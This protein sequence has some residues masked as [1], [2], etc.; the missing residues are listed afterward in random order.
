MKEIWL[1]IITDI[2]DGGLTFSGAFDNENSAKECI[3]DE[4]LG[5]NSLLYKL[6]LSEVKSEYVSPYE[7]K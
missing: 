5:A 4:F 6:D 2:D 1:A 7:D 3:K